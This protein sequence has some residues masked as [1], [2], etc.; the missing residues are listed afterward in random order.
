MIDESVLKSMAEVLGEQ[1]T[2][3]LLNEFW[4]TVEEKLFELRQAL[5]AKNESR[6]LALAHELK[7]SAGNFG[8]L[9]FSRIAAKLEQ[10]V[11]DPVLAAQHI[12]SMSETAIETQRQAMAFFKSGKAA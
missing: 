10:D 5:G 4:P 12:E 3:E 8:G 2:A 9:R 1:K 11:C 6:I 7:G